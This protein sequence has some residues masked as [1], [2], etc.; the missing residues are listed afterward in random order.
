MSLNHEVNIDGVDIWDVTCNVCG[1][2]V[3][4]ACDEDALPTCYAIAGMNQIATIRCVRNAE[5]EKRLCAI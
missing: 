5:G 1:E 2:T 4:I 3:E